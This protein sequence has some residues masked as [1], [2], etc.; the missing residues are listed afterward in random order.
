MNETEFII[1]SIAYYGAG[2]GLAHLF[3]TISETWAE[4][5]LYLLFVGI[6]AFIVVLSA[7]PL[8]EAL[9]NIFITLSFLF[10]YIYRFSK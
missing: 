7:M 8:L 1:Y 6:P 4:R 2:Y 10:G 5:P 3:K 9:N